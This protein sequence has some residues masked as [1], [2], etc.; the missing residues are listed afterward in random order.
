MAIAGIVIGSR[1]LEWHGVPLEKPPADLDLILHSWALPQTQWH[2]RPSMLPGVLIDYTEG[3]EVHIYGAYPSHRLIAQHIAGVTTIGGLRLSVPTLSALWAIKRGALVYAPRL[4][5]T[6]RDFD[7]LTKLV[8]PVNH[9]PSLD[10]LSK[11]IAREAR[12]R[13]CPYD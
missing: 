7:R 12:G 9:S 3:V 4:T 1:A 13:I 8:G 11:A 10:E 5:K 2:L 6:Q